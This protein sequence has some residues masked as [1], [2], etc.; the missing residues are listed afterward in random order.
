MIQSRA[1][2]LY[3]ILWQLNERHGG[4][5]IAEWPLVPEHFLITSGALSHANDLIGGLAVNERQ[6]LANLNLDG[7]AVLSEAF[8]GALAPAL[9]RTQAYDLVKAAVARARGS[10][11]TLAEEL[12]GTPEIAGKISSAEL[13]RMLDVKQHVG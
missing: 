3:T 10:G 4:V 2:G 11:K 7:G 8:A 6:M 13:Q 5:W 1:A 9:G 12:S